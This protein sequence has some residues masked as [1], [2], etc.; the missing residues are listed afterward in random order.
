MPYLFTCPHCQTKTEVEDRFSGLAGECVTC[1][2]PIE[3]PNFAKQASPDNPKTRENKFLSSLLAAGVVL[4]LIL[5]LL[6]A[7]VRHG[8]QTVTQLQTN[9]ARASSIRNLEKI[10][11]ALNA[12][13]ADHGT[14]PPPFTKN[15][16]GRP[17]QSWRVL[18]LPYL[19]EEELY[20][21]INLGADWDNPDNMSVA[22]NRVPSAFSHPD[23]SVGRIFSESAYYLITGPGTLFP[24]TG[25]L[26]PND[27]I[28]DTTKTLLV[29]EGS[30][31]MTTNLWTEPVDIN[32]TQAQGIGGNNSNVGGLLDEGAAA[33]TVDGRGHYIA[34]TMPTATF[35]ALISPRGGEPLADDTL[36]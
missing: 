3:L 9:R 13:S 31:T 30:P 1:G 22:Y 36:D 26:G 4:V 17:M 2:E 16:A 33:A 29:V 35:R 27:V 15:Q 32:V 24:A 23:G 21:S 11:A 10:A 14:Y 12:Y 8:S 28:D 19:G 6:F 25:P 18:I 34:D 20:D 7:V 5:C